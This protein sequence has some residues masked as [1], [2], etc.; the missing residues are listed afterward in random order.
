M[1]KKGEK[2]YTECNVKIPLVSQTKSI[3]KGDILLTKKKIL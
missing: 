2:I 1:A 3:F